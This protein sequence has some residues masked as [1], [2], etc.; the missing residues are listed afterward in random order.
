MHTEQPLLYFAY[1]LNLNPV[2][3]KLKCSEMEIVGVSRLPGY[4]LAFFEYSPVWD[5]A[6]ETLVPDKHSEVWGVLYRL[7]DYSWDELDNCED[8][9]IDGTGAYF[10]YPVEVH[11]TDS[12]TRLAMMYLKSRL[13]N[14]SLASS[15]YMTQVLQG[16]TAH[17]LPSPYIEKL[18]A[19][20]T[21][22]ACYPVPR[23]PAYDRSSSC[24][25][26]DCEACMIDCDSNQ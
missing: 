14:A 4:K 15:E 12:T 13:G 24:S 1:G 8:A 9:R 20:E 18:Q 7:T 17:G 10:R 5:S 23:R 19:I 26:A 16:A 6:M 2:Q 11:G 3:M 25:G 21:K 22:P